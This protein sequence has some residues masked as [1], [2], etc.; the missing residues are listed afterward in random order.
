MFES[1]CDAST[2]IGAYVN[3]Q[4]L[5]DESE[6]IRGLL[7]LAECAPDQAARIESSAVALVEV[8]R[9][10]RS[11]KSGLDAFLDAYDLSSAEGIVLMCLAEALLRIPDAPTADRLIADKLGAGDWERHLG[12]SDSLFVNAS[13]WGLMLTGR[14]AQQNEFPSAGPVAFVRTLVARLGEPV[15]RSAM[16]QAMR[17]MGRQ[18]VMGRTIQDALQ[19]STEQDYARYLFSF[20]M[21]GEAAVTA[22]DA[23]NYFQ[24]Y[25]DAIEG[26][27]EADAGPGEIHSRHGI[28]VKLSA[29][30]PRFEF[31]QRERVLR[32]VTPRLIE[33]ATAASRRNIQLTIDAEEAD[34]LELTLAVFEAVHAG[35]GRNDWP[36]FGIVVQAYQR[37]A[38]AVISWLDELSA[39]FGRRIPVR[40][41]KG[42]Y[43]DTEI[44][45]AQE[46]GLTN[47]PVFTRK[48]N[49]DASYLACARSLIDKR[50]TLSPQ[51]AT[52]NAHTVAYVLE[53][54]PAGLEYEFQRLHGMGEAMYDHILGTEDPSPRCRV[55]APVGSH[56]HLLPYLVRRLLENGANTSFINRIVQENVPAAELVRDPVGRIRSDSVIPDPRIAAP[57]KLY[58]ENRVNSVGINFCDGEVM[59]GLGRDMGLAL[60][61]S[62]V[63]APVIDGKAVPGKGWTVWCPSERRQAIGQ[64]T[65]A[66]GAQVD[67][68]IGVAQRG[69]PAWNAADVGARAG[70]LRRAADLLEENRSELVALCVAE[71]GKCIVDAVAEIREA[72][73]YLRYYAVEAESLMSVPIELPGPTGERNRMILKGRGVFACISPWN[74]PVAIFTG[75]IAAALVTGNTVLAKPAEQTSLVAAR[76]VELLHSAGVPFDVL[77]FVPGEGREVGSRIV[78]DARVHGVVFTGSTETAR[79]INRALAMKD[80]PLA[81]LIAET[82]GQNAMIVDSTALPEQVVKDVVESAF[83]SAGQR[84]SA[85]RVLYLQEEI[86]DQIL[87]L[88]AGCMA[89]LKIG[90]PSRLDT[91]IGPVI[92]DAARD[93][94]NAHR[95]KILRSCKLVYECILPAGLD[96]GSFFPPCVVEIPDISI[97]ERE[98]F[99]PILHVIRFRRDALDQ[100]LADIATT[101]YGLTFGVQSRIEDRSVDIS[102]RIH[103]GNIYVNRNM[104]GAVVGVQPFGGIGLSGTGP[105]A[106]GPH[107]LQRF[108]TERTVSINTAAIGGN[109]DLLTLTNE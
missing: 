67:E 25:S 10:D 64:V 44:K 36:G 53:M 57:L 16:M 98:V 96:R 19:R 28:S 2:P 56:V 85:L 82:G 34:R 31:A 62:R 39:R 101:G 41:V 27:G 66:S 58:G 91:D 43:W 106:G 79:A 76:V 23:E 77:Q 6:V 35:L 21:L 95:A 24:A 94:L 78:A 26:V 11:K 60:Q 70:V 14:L 105:K 47:Y 83:N 8:M 59:S 52:H 89:E 55:Y 48:R 104:I 93:R 7:T 92:D 12:A 4:Y 69:F 42:A 50:G 81:T 71:A 97:L 18:F 49:T 46:D 15:V 102:E 54:A 40:L 22:S 30:S 72:V 68:A 65:G 99:G 29:L 103:A 100:I 63:A 108:V 5:A 17:I 109:A 45:R 51:F 9:R 107:Y 75:Q 32:E 84:C 90:D 61:G 37:R 13:T 74:F 87:T 86:A 1:L 20:D 88:L 80:G 33:L 3:S 73:D 38:L